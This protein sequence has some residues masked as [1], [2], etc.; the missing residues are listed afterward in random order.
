MTLALWELIWSEYWE[1]SNGQK[2]SKYMNHGGVAL[3]SWRSIMCSEAVLGLH[4][5]GV[6]EVRMKAIEAEFVVPSGWPG[7][8]KKESRGVGYEVD[9]NGWTFLAYLLGIL[10]REHRSISGS[11]WRALLR[12]AIEPTLVI[13]GRA[14]TGRG[15]V[16][17]PI[18]AVFFYHHHTTKHTNKQTLD[19]YLDSILTLSEILVLI[20]EEEEE[21]PV[22]GGGETWI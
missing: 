5:S 18:A 17:N 20:E 9:V 7:R 19:S 21:T 4:R 22:K 13:S 1:G 15:G 3:L 8:G 2:W 10:N 14:T 6:E 16:P 12:L 11:I